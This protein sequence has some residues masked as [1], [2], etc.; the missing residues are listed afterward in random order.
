[1]QGGL[2][3]SL[4]PNGFGLIPPKG[5]D[6]NVRLKTCTFG[7][8]PCQPKYLTI[9]ASDSPLLRRPIQQVY[10]VF[11]VIQSFQNSGCCCCV[12]GLLSGV[13]AEV[14]GSTR[15][16]LQSACP[17]SG[18]VPGGPVPLL[19]MAPDHN[20]PI[21]IAGFDYRLNHLRQH[22]AGWGEIL[23]SCNPAGRRSVPPCPGA[24]CIA[25][26]ARNAHSPVCNHC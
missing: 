14:N 23:P 4:K 25:T 15:H 22:A 2:S 12:C 10:V 20:H 16:Y 7:N 6:Q 18:P 9:E 21:L 13:W 26:T 11:P 1:M 19:W 8:T 24:S 17:R 3:Q 5:D